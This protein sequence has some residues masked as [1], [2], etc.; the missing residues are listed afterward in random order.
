MV[1]E[2]AG[3]EEASEAVEDVLCFVEGYVAFRR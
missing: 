2:T 1:C 3:F